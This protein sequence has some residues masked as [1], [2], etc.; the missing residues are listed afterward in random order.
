MSVEERE[1]PRHRVV[2]IAETADGVERERKDR[3]RDG[4]QDDALDDVRDEHAPESAR[5]RID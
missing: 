3:E 4:H 2:E 1:V 5:E